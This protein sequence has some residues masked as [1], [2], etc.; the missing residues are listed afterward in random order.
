MKFIIPS[1][2]LLRRIMR[3]GLLQVILC[4]FV[5][6]IALA[7]D[8]Q[9][10]E[11]L[12]RSVTLQCKDQAVKVVLDR[13]EKAAGVRFIY[14]PEL[15]QS[16]RKVSLD[17]RDKRLADILTTLLVPLKITYEVVG[18]QILLK[19]TPA[20]SGITPDLIKTETFSTDQS[21]EQTVTGTVSDENGGLLPGVS[22]VVKN[23]TRGT[24]TD[25]EG[26]YKL[27]I[28]DEGPTAI[29]IFSFV[30][31]KSQEVTIGNR[32]TIDIQLATDN[33]SLDEV[34]VVGYGMV[35][36]SDLTGSVA[37]IDEGIIKA[38]PIVSLD[39]AMQGRI[40]GVQVTSNS[41]APGG[42]TTIRIRGTGSVNAG[43]DPLYVIDGFPTGDLNSINPNDIE[44]IEI[45]KD[46]SATAIYGSRGSNGVVLVTTKRGK[47]GQSSINFESYYG[48]QSVR[49]KVPLLNAREYA[50]FI[51]E[52]R[53]NGGGA[54]YFDGSTA[55]RPLPESLGEGTDW[56]DEVFRTAP[57]QS[58]QLSFTGGETKT[59]YAISGNYYDQQGIILNSY[60]KRF[61]LRANLDREVKPW[62]TIG[63]SMQGAHTRSNSSRTATD[64]GAAGGVTNAAL[65]YAPVFPIYASPGIYYRDQSTLNGS[66]VDN[67]V[68]LAKEVT[69]LYYT[70]RL[71]T[72][73]YADF[74]IGPHLTF[75]TT[76]GADL[77]ASKQNNYAT[78]LIQLGASTN[79]SA[80][81][82]SALNINYLNEN[83]LTY[84]RTFA[85]KHNLTALLGYTSQ[86]YNIESVT[87]NAINFNDDFALY[88]NLGAGATLQNP[89][90]GAADW[91]LISYL[92]RINYGF[93]SRFLLTL[94]ARRDGSSRFGPNNKYGFFPSGAFAWRVINEKFL[95][96]QKS[97]SDLKL[98]LSYGV[99][100]NQGIGD[101]SYLSNISITQ[102]ILGGATPTIQS[103]GVPATISNYD[104]RWEKSTQFDAG[105]DIGVLN[106][107]IR[108]TTDYYKKITSD[109]LFS[110]NVPQTTGYSTI[111]Q[112]IGK[113]SNQ[114]WEF[115]LST[116]NVDSK[117][118]KWTTDFNISF[119]QNKILT[120]D[121]RSE[122]TSGI[123]SGHLQVF[124]TALLKVGEPLGNFY[125]RVVDGLFQ[126]QEEVNASAQKT[127]K[128][129]DLKYKDLNGDGV[130]NDLDRTII[131][132]GN[133]KFFGGFNNTFTY[134]GFDL[135]IFLQ[136]S[137]GNSILNFG[138]FGLYNLNGNNNQSKDVLNRWTPT[139]TNT[140]IPRANSAGGQRILSTFHVEDGSYLR[141]KNISLG[142]TLPQLVSK[143]LALQQVKIYVSA[144]NWLTFTNFKGYD[145][146]VN[147]AGG[148][149]ISQGIDY[150]SYPTAKTFLAGLNVKF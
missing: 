100:G 61:S 144:Q 109:L 92:A 137:S 60:F 7:H 58:Y 125:G 89:A 76:L 20:S 87:A 140:D 108:L 93:D 131:G 26:K 36:K 8:G 113:V 95:Q 94:T 21:A 99:A 38:T 136:G 97:I 116:A 122:F 17:F 68:G 57:I 63:L 71:L 72:N 15:I 111:Q 41:A 115:A 18:N 132:N 22:V 134:K 146:E 85:T 56:Q 31:Y 104:L 52:A 138:R 54:A 44:S 114:G 142:Y 143:K 43:N 50:T 135:T 74:K 98:R 14:S 149:P 34:V 45:L 28:P 101:Y 90:S 33:K 123:G 25:A 37:R 4:V 88:N 2:L 118:F 64:G 42:S 16:Y 9:A 10:Q 110:V 67:P 49:R 32:T 106:N 107:R 75:R 84:N 133:P 121:G 13:V 77:L 40:A 112:N 120:L 73:F 102:G 55:A 127:E 62:L 1:P 35:K 59:R 19:R 11:V 129:G 53:I 48:V 47:T 119:N 148:N 103:G 126:T 124:N 51:N 30:G 83:T 130:I 39:R 23:T 5:V 82:V 105:L 150:G 139:N 96:S 46:A 80:S 29:L 79:G 86:A 69:N 3:I 141:L 12:N 81:V 91:A 128:P 27:T 65:N 70:L 78:R 145:P 147:F 117:D 24:T 6:S 66:L